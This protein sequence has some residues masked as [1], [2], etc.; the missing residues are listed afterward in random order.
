MKTSTV[1]SSVFCQVGR[2]DQSLH[3]L[4]SLS[5]EKVPFGGGQAFCFLR[6]LL[7]SYGNLG[8]GRDFKGRMFQ[9]AAFRILAF[10]TSLSLLFSP[11]STIPWNLTTNYRPAEVRALVT[12]ALGEGAQVLRYGRLS[13]PDSLEAIGAVTET[14]IP[15]S[16]DGTAVSRL[17][18]FRQQGTQ[19]VTAL[20]DHKHIRNDAGTLA[21]SSGNVTSSPIYRVVFFQHRFED[22]RQRWVIRLTPIN[23]AGERICPPVHVSWNEL[24]GRYQEISLQ[25]YGFQPEVHGDIS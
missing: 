5:R 21:A 14:G 22:G 25:G 13:A 17:A 6:L 12:R 24:V 1:A 7:C 9:A 3:P 20:S 16:P 10:S 4:V 8:W 19:W 15:A 23:R 11:N 18:L 2:S